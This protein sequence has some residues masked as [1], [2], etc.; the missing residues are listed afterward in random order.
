[1]AETLT[2]GPALDCDNDGFVP[3]S[4]ADAAKRPDC[5]LCDE[6][7]GEP[8]RLE[9]CPNGASCDHEQHDFG[10]NLHVVPLD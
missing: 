7:A 10:I 6:F 2:P 9:A 8:V 3:L 1:M 5:P 4:E